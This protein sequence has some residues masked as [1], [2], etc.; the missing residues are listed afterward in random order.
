MSLVFRTDQ[1]TPLTNDQLD[2]N[3]KY[4][5]DQLILKYNVSAFTN[6][7]IS[8][9]LRT[10]SDGQ[11]T[12]ALSQA[13]A[14]NAWTLRDLSPSS[15][16]PSSTD[17][18]SL[19]I[20]SSAG[21][22]SVTTVYGN[23]SGI[24]SNATL[25]ANATKLVTARNINDVAFDGTANITILDSTKLSNQG[26]N[27]YGSLILSPSN[28]VVAS[29]NFGNSQFAPSNPINGDMWVT[30]SGFYYRN[31]DATHAFAPLDSP[32]FTGLVRAPGYTGV[33][34]SIITISHLDAAKVVLNSAIGLKSDIQ[35]PAFTG[36]PTAPTASSAINSAQI[37][38][39]A[40]AR[41]IVDSKASD[42]TT[43]YQAYTT[44]QIGYNNTT[45]NQS[46][47]LKANLDS[48][49]FTGVPSA[50]TATSGTNNTQIATTAFVT[51]A[52]N[53]VLQQLNA[54][55]QSLND[56]IAATR[57][58]P[59]GAVFYMLKATVPYGYFEANGQ[60][61]SRSTYIDLWNYLG[62][63]NTG[64]GSTTFNVVDLR[65]EFIR[66]WDDGRGQDAGRAIGSYQ[67]SSNLQHTH[68]IGS[69]DSTATYGVAYIPEFVS[70]VDSGYGPNI[71][72]SSSGENESRPRNIALMPII[73]W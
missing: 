43:A 27:L 45:I 8:S 59:V 52:T 49:T 11:S 65:A 29:I 55:S 67:Q 20:R 19:V 63:P 23:L 47:A 1:T 46:I 33:S 68:L 70:A 16:V 24:A 32:T 15:L 34:D 13:N 35:S 25:A 53:A 39:T 58:V 22:I 2:G 7:N 48:P 37:A 69:R 51:S 41:T 3:F 28:S 50:G 10:V 14:L 72:T 17:K 31:S 56:A 66:G 12:L 62:Q 64:N 26:G 61:V 9:V 71:S 73:K 21:E 6:T 30:T 5:R 57:P 60:A 54:L 36:I 44:T 4:L 18:S 38:T 42:L 40:F